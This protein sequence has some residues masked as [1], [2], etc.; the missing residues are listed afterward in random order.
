VLGVLAD[1]DQ[2]DV[3]E[4]GPDALVAL[5]R[6]DLC[7]EVEALA[8]ADVDRAEAAAHRSGYWPLQRDAVL[9][10]RGEDV[11]GEWIAPVL[12]HHVGDGVL[13]IPVEHDSGCVGPPPP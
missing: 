2:V 6:P 7:V 13:N 12:V 5:A 1:D 8:Q 10:D 11:V 9:T 3:L 4:A